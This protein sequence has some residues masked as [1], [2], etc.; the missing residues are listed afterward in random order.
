MRCGG[1]GQMVIGRI[2][3]WRIVC[4]LFLFL[5]RRFSKW[6]TDRP[7]RSSRCPTATDLETGTSGMV[8][9]GTLRR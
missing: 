2:G 9:G 1:G 3:L 6:D 4:A 8:D 7:P 5:R